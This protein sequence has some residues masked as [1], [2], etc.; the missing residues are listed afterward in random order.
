MNNSMV[1]FGFKISIEAAFTIPKSVEGQVARNLCT[2]ISADKGA[3][4]QKHGWI[5]QEKVLPPGGGT[6]RHTDWSGSD[7]VFSFSQP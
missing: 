6:S 7:G 2:R 5:F 1:V 4:I 3:A